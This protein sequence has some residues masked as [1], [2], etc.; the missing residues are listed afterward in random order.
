MS[1]NDFW[2]TIYIDGDMDKDDYFGKWYEDPKYVSK[3]PHV[4]VRREVVQPKPSTD[5]TEVYQNPT[6][7]VMVWDDNS[8]DWYIGYVDL[9]RLKITV[10]GYED[11]C[12]DHF[13]IT[14]WLPMPDAPDT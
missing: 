12:D 13:N 8:R 2:D 11:Q 4:F 7:P 10:E 5:F 1:H 9:D 14:H 3:P 6:K